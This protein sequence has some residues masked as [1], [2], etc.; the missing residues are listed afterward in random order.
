M[1]IVQI[2]RRAMITGMEASVICLALLIFGAA[3]VISSTVVG[4][5]VIVNGS[6]KMA[7]AVV[8]ESGNDSFF[9]VESA[10]RVAALVSPVSILFGTAGALTAVVGGAGGGAP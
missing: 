10:G 2:Q 4:I 6:S 9:A 1:F 8:G 7:A 3:L 5:S